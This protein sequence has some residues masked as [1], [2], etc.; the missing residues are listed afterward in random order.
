MTKIIEEGQTY[1][2]EL[3]A[4]LEKISKWYLKCYWEKSFKNEQRMDIFQT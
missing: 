2:I 3:N 1:M 4:E